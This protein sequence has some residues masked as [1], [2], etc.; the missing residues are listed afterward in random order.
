MIF[1]LKR[2]FYS[3]RPVSYLFSGFCLPPA[4]LCYW[5]TTGFSRY[6]VLITIYGKDCSAPAFSPFSGPFSS[7]FTTIE[8]SVR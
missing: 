6:S 2:A 4:R 7:V 5:N 8:L 1:K 3:L